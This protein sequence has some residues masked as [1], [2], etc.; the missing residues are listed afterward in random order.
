[1]QLSDLPGERRNALVAMF[2]LLASRWPKIFAASRSGELMPVWATALGGVETSVLEPAALQFCAESS[3]KYAPDPAE[4]A[5]FARGLQAKHLRI[6]SPEQ[7]PELPAPESTKQ[8]E[9][10]ESMSRWAFER[11]A[12]WPLVAEVWA[13]LLETAP[14][15]AHRA[16]VRDGT[17]DRL[18]FRDAVAAVQNGARV[19]RR[20]P[21][22]QAVA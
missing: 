15:D 4:F 1:M 18:V 9:R 22:A 11:L 14:D 7:T 10:I 21:L 16:M 12:S 19:M 3:A 2:R 6:A 17:I 20:G 8:S 13:L 5:K